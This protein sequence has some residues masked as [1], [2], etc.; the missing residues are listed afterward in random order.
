VRQF[1]ADFVKANTYLP[2]TRGCAIGYHCSLPD[3]SL[4]AWLFVFARS[5]FFRAF[6]PV[7]AGDGLFCPRP[8]VAVAGQFAW[9]WESISIYFLAP[10]LGMLAAAALMNARFPPSAMAAPAASAIAR[11]ASASYTVIWT[12]RK[13]GAYRL[14]W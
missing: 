1:S 5:R 13:F 6:S 7:H 2:C 12:G 3:F 10:C 8:D 11:P 9:V 4:I 14:R